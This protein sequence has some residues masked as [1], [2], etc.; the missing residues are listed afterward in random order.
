MLLNNLIARLKHSGFF[1]FSDF[2]VA[3]LFYLF[4]AEISYI[5]H[6]FFAPGLPC[7]R[8]A[9]KGS[10]STAVKRADTAWRNFMLPEEAAWIT[11]SLS[12]P[13]LILQSG[14]KSANFV[15]RLAT[16][17]SGSTYFR[18]FTAEISLKF[19]CVYVLLPLFFSGKPQFYDFTAEILLE[20]TIPTSTFSAANP[21][22]DTLPLK[23]TV[24]M[25][26]N[27]IKFQR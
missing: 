13:V 3:P 6:H 21:Y 1:H 11:H 10:T 25:W 2:S 19:C 22:F 17:F 26:S 4:T 16:H 9:F 12:K 24:Q 18:H 7:W 23:S 20:F 15:C 5:T 27:Q 8:S 14:W